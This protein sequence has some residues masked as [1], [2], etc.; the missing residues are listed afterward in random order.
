MTLS[1]E[2]LH[3]LAVHPRIKRLRAE[4][5]G[6]SVALKCHNFDHLSTRVPPSDDI[7]EGIEKRRREINELQ[8]D[9]Q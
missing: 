8:G 2:E 4:I 9:D 3:A 1:D 6:L 5:A 7:I